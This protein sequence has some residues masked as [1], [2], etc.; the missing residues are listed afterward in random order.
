[1]VVALEPDLLTQGFELTDLAVQF[2]FAMNR[3][4][5]V[6][7]DEFGSPSISWL[8]ALMALHP[9]ANHLFP[10]IG[11][12]VLVQPLYRY[13]AT[14][15]SPSGWQQTGL[16]RPLAGS[17]AHGAQL[18]ND[19]IVFLE[20]L[21]SWAKESGVRLVYSLPWAYMPYEQIKEFRHQNIEFLLQV[22]TFVEVLKDPVLGADPATLPAM[23]SSMP[24]TSNVI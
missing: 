6:R 4:D 20:S 3:A 13:H 18:S 17:S 10:L 2:S 24:T 23:I 14:D 22:S 12:L 19:G 11:K 9:G 8:S 5:W 21:K 15:L 1:L 16:R 7:K